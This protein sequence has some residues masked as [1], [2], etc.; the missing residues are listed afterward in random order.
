MGRYFIISSATLY[1]ENIASVSNHYI[2]K[3]FWNTNK[4]RPISDN[5]WHSNIFTHKTQIF[6]SKK[7]F[8]Q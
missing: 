3:L 8:H 6:L 5:K 2:K 1:N 7:N 4:D